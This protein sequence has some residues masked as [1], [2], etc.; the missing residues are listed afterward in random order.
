M[1]V[2]DLEAKAADARAGDEV[3]I[4]E[5]RLR[6][7]VTHPGATVFECTIPSGARVPAPHY[8]RDVDE[9]LYGLTGTLSVT[10]DGGTRL[11]QRGDALF[12]PRGA[13]HH[14]E[15]THAKDAHFLALLTPGAIGRAYFEE[16]AE[17]INAP[18]RPDLA[19]A[20]EVML[21]HGLA[22]V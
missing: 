13:V 7:L 19:K 10:L 4:G 5:L 14:H 16:I 11:L 6:F 15:N 8:H 17:V 9:T 21:R 18:G 3:R 20:K 1:E 12:I 2:G 22:P